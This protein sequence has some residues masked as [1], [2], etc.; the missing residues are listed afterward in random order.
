MP[1]RQLRREPVR[2]LRR[3]FSRGN[4]ARRK[5]LLQLR[6]FSLFLR[7]KVL[8]TTNFIPCHSNWSHTH[9]SSFAHN[10]RSHQIEFRLAARSPGPRW[11]QWRRGRGRAQGSGPFRNVRNSLSQIAGISSVKYRRCPGR[12]FFVGRLLIRSPITQRQLHAWSMCRLYSTEYGRQ[13]SVMAGEFEHRSS[14]TSY[15]N[16]L[17]SS[18]RPSPAI[19]SCS[20]LNVCPSRN[21]IL[22]HC[23]GQYIFQDF[24]SGASI[25]S[26]G[27]HIL[28]KFR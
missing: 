3:Q 7:K 25:D 20:T 4:D 8:T 23:W 14:L 17:V 16:S 2:L 9:F 6:Q 15:Q 5:S 28:D 18:H 26:G 13:G 1:L 10:R 12:R 22:R 21:E 11:D 19:I 27:Q 24:E